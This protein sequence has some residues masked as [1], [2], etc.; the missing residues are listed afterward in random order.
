MVISNGVIHLQLDK[1]SILSDAIEFVRELQKQVNDLQHQLEEQSDDEETKNNGQT[2]KLT[3]GLKCEHEKTPNGNN[4]GAANDGVADPKK[5]NHDASTYDR[6][7]R[8]M[9]VTS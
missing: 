4:I 7:P 5:Q 3:V 9:E 8:Q 2:E 6:K 1:A